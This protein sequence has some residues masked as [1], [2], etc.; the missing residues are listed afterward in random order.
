M[1]IRPKGH[2]PSIV[3][4]ARV[5]GNLSN[6]FVPTRG[7]NFELLLPSARKKLLDEGLFEFRDGEYV[8]TAKGRARL[9]QLESQK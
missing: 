1:S 5:N 3:Q 2:R 7:A 9:A 4:I 8:I 6:V